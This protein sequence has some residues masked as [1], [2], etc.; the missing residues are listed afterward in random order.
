MSFFLVFIGSGLGGAARYGL[1]VLSI[2]LFGLGFP[3]GTLII[4]I[5]GSVLMGV[6]VAL[7]AKSSVS[8][9]ELRL[10]LT[11]GLIGGF[12]TFSTFSLDA[13]ALWY[14]GERLASAS[15]VALS[16]VASL[17]ALVASMI[18]VRRWL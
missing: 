17:A 14:R 7:F 9:P 8:G 2:R 12:T 15:Y 16:V 11:T 13:G 6:T 3:F 4:N 10:F 5:F 18:I 1:G